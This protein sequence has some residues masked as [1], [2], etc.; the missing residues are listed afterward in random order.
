MEIKT[1]NI[2]R[3]FYPFVILAILSFTVRFAFLSYPSQT[4][5]DEVHFGK[6]VSAYSTHEYYFDIHPPLGKLLIAGWAK[7]VNFNPSFDFDHIGEAAAPQLFSTLRFLPALFGSIFVLLFSYFAYL[8]SRSKKTALI[9]GMLVLLDNAFLVQSKFIFID[10]FLLFFGILALC[11][12]ILWQKQKSFSAR[13][14]FFLAMTGISFGLTISIK[15]TGLAVL[16]IIAAT[17]LAKIFIPRIRLWLSPFETNASDKMISVKNLKEAIVGLPIMA[18]LGFLVYLIPFAVHF[19]LLDKSG[20]GDAFM[21]AHFQSELKNGKENTPDPLSFWEKFKE[22]NTTMYTASAG[23]TAT[24][25]FGSTWNEWP[26]DKKP[27][28]YW[29]QAPTSDNEERIGKIY[30]LGNPIIWWFAFGAIGL[31]LI[32]F[33]SKKERRKITP[34]MYFLIIAYFANLL[35]F[36][37]VERVAFL[38]HYLLSATFA[39]LLLSIYL[40]KLWQKDKAIFTTLIIAIAIFFVILTPLSYGW[41]MPPGLDQFEMKIIDLLS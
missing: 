31:T 22:L 29:Y 28:Y 14:F 23:L 16:G 36:A 1:Q 39:V 41:L 27:I 8:I 17:L 4:V 37:G 18:I 20:P 30:F 21:S 12:F 19:E 34:F 25:P 6:F 24:H 2:L 11:F 9:A 7:L 32:R 26:F 35:P 3:K 13:W 38:Y 10:I 5:F 15:W 40:E 33:A